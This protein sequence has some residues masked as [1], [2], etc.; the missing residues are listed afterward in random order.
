MSVKL[1]NKTL[2]CTFKPLHVDVVLECGP[3]DLRVLPPQRTRLADD[4]S[5]SQRANDSIGEFAVVAL[6]LVCRAFLAEEL[7]HALRTGD[8]DVPL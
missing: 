6:L 4:V 5:A 8:Q 7:L 2:R 1:I 3:D